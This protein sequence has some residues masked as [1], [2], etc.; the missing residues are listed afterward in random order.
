M[1]P[2]RTTR[3]KTAKTVNDQILNF[4]QA[5]KKILKTNK[6]IGSKVGITLRMSAKQG[7]DKLLDIHRVVCAKPS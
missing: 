1:H 2:R 6:R 3:L 5:F 7:V 4:C